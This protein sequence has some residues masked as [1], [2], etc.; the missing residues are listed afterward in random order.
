MT[1]QRT[2]E[3]QD[4]LQAVETRLS[5]ACAA[6]GRARSEITLVVVTK[7][8]P[9]A[10]VLRLA[11]LGVSH[12]GENRHQEAVGKRTDYERAGGPPLTWHFVG[13]LQSNKAA[14]VADWADVVQSVD[15][16]RLLGPLGRAATH[17]GRD[18]DVLLQVSLDE[19]PG[20]RGRGGAD[21]ADLPALAGDVAA[22]GGLTLC[23]LMAVAPL[24]SDPEPA[25]DRL[26]ALSQRLRVDHPGATWISA[27]MSGD[28]EQAVACGAT[29]VR[30]GTAVLG[31]RPAQR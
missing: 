11:Q 31:S 16:P 12:V 4:N 29:H 25:F 13:R 3:L 10:D 21:P 9:A 2:T 22:T 19:L 8:F 26:A 17:R 7:H 15:R 23:G 5:Q 24:G 20:T 1:D 6:A 28:L 27:G 18:L 30:V 14:A